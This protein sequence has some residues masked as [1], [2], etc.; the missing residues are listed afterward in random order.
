M[1]KMCYAQIQVEQYLNVM[2]TVTRMIVQYAGNTVYM[3]LY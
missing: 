2:E 1:S 3:Y